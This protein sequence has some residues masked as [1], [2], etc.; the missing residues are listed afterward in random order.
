MPV[1]ATWSF[2]CVTAGRDFFPLIGAV[3]P[4]GFTATQFCPFSAWCLS[5]DGVLLPTERTVSQAESVLAGP[6]RR[7]AGGRAR[8][9]PIP[10]ILWP[11]PNT[12]Y[13]SGDGH[14]LLHM[15]GCQVRR[16]T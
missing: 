6:G 11:A 13:L 9:A 15:D 16:L 12:E 7:R 10:P 8:G 3:S 1:A 2:P 14:I 4:P 5:L